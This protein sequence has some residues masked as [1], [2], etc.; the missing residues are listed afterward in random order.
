[1][2]KKQ[3]KKK[4][5]EDDG[6]SITAWMH[7]HGEGV[8]YQ[9]SLDHGC[10]TA[11]SRSGPYACL[12]CRKA[13]E[14]E[15]PDRNVEEAHALIVRRMHGGHATYRASVTTVVTSSAYLFNFL[16]LLLCCTVAD[17]AR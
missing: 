8:T 17:F 1:M 14:A 12:A 10:C 6:R 15:G 9:G 11:F 4:G 2:A 5:I 7:G 3:N 13:E 16:L